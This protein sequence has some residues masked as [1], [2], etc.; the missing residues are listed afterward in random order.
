MSG[1]STCWELGVHLISLA[2]ALRIAHQGG[3]GWHLHSQM[4]SVLPFVGI[5]GAGAEV[6]GD[7]K[8]SRAQG[9][10]QK[11]YDSGGNLLARS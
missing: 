3:K 8:I 5:G 7:S 11:N 2:D 9:L 10:F 1:P 6:S 4:L